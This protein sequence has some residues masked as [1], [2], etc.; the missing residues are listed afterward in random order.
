[1]RKRL[2][3]VKADKTADG[4]RVGLAAERGRSEDRW[5]NGC[6]TTMTLKWIAWRL[7]SWTYVF[8]LLAANRSRKQR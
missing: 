1:M 8:N 2:G 5:R 6:E 3:K 7:Q 4:A